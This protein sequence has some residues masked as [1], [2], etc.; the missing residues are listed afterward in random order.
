MC[1]YECFDFDFGIPNGVS[2][3]C[4]GWAGYGCWVHRLQLSLLNYCKVLC[5]N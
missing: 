3:L 5:S 2:G 1:G 4:M